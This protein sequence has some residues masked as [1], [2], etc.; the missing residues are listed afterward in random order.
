MA[1]A[2]YVEYLIRPSE[3]WQHQLLWPADLGKGGDISKIRMIMFKQNPETIMKTSAT[4]NF[5]PKNQEMSP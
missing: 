2:F 5:P 1:Y 3:M 4:Q